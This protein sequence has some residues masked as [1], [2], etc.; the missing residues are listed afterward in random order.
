MEPKYP[1]LGENVSITCT[2][3]VSPAM[4]KSGIEIEWD[5]PGKHFDDECNTSRLE[6]HQENH[7]QRIDDN[8]G[9]AKSVIISK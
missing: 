6:C 9:R 1:V 3:E 4:F 5:G 2:V 7:V 8:R